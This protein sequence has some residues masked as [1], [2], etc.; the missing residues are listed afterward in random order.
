MFQ[1]SGLGNAVS[2]L[3]SLHQ[4]TRLPTLL[5]V[6]WRGEPGGKPDEPQHRLMGAVTPALLDLMEIPWAPFPQ[7]SDGIGPALERAT[8][9]MDASQTPYALI[10]SHG[11]VAPYPLA[12][13]AAQQPPGPEPHPAMAPPAVLPCR[14][15]VLAAIRAAAG[16]RDALLATT[17]YT[18]RELYALGDEERQLYMV[19]SMGCVSSLALGVALCRPARRVVAIDGDGAA[20]MRL[21]ALATIGHEAPP[22]LVHVLLDNGCHESTGGQATAAASVDFARIAAACGYRRVVRAA[23]PD[24]VAAAVADPA[25]GPTFVAVRIRPGT[26]A[27]LPRPTVTP[28]AVAERMRRFLREEV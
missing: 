24:A 10:M 12:S 2:P 8:A 19:G 9:H 14:G 22:N 26:S 13:T 4:I 16:P 18:G 5:I 23:T 6:T 1:N 21:G 3:T 25:P 17:G 28:E 27:N 7:A 11:A 15:D 20:L